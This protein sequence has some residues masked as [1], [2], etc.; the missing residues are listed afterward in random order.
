MKKLAAAL[1]LILPLLALP[2][3]AFPQVPASPPGIRNFTP[4]DSTVACA[5]AVTPEAAADVG[6]AGFVSMVN[7]RTAGEEGVDLAAIEKAAAQA[8]LR[9]FHVPFSS[10][11]PTPEPID[12]FLEIARD[13]SNEPMLIYCASGGRAAMLLAIKRVMI[14]L[15]SVEKAMAEVP[16]LSEGMRPA[17][18]EFG[19]AYLKQHGKAVP[20]K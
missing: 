2:S 9:Y 20:G 15:W 7:L 12:R 1:A 14:D 16:S 5:G 17:V 11:N 8:G 10:S 3:A 6:K 13:R 4:V 18:R 19:L